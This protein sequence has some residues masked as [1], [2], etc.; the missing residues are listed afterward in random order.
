[1]ENGEIFLRKL[2]KIERKNDA[3]KNEEKI[4]EKKK[5]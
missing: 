1:M 3:R 4:E 5:K 2:R